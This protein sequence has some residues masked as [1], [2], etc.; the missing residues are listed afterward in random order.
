MGQD[1][2]PAQLEPQPQEARAGAVEDDLCGAE[3]VL[4]EE[5]GARVHRHEGGGGGEHPGE[6]AAE[7]GDGSVQ[8]KEWA[9]SSIGAGAEAAAPA[10]LA[11]GGVRA[12]RT[13]A[14]RVG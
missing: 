8:V 12:L 1:V 11:A 14:T 6:A 5:L 2:S 13:G 4:A 7:V 9:R 10:G 3:A